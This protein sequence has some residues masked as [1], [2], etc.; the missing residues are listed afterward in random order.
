MLK[1]RCSFTVVQ[2]RYDVKL[3]LTKTK[4]SKMKLRLY[5]QFKYFK[6]NYYDKYTTLSNDDS[7]LLRITGNN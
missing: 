5:Y 4:I 7:K 2:V 3:V 1:T 6:M